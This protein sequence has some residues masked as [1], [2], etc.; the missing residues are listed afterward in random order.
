MRRVIYAVSAAC[1]FTFV[2]IVILKRD[3]ETAFVNSLKYIAATLGVPGAFIGLMAASGRIHDID[4]WITG[5][6]NFAFYF[7]ITSGCCSNFLVKEDARQRDNP[8]LEVVSVNACG[9]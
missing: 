5:T 6:A 1:V 8:S 4:L 3:S 2:P 7:A 9:C